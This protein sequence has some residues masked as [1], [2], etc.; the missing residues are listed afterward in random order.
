MCAETTFDGTRYYRIESSGRGIFSTQL[1][2]Y[3]LGK[4][5]SQ[6]PPDDNDVPKKR[7]EVLR[8]SPYGPICNTMEASAVVRPWVVLRT[9]T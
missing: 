1:N 9:S 3:P 5:T 6:G 8:T 7:P 2:V 4:I